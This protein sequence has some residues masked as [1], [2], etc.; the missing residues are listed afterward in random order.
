MDVALCLYDRTHVW[1]NGRMMAGV[2]ETAEREGE[3]AALEAE[4]AQVCG[5]STPPLD[6]W[7]T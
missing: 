2:A 4:M 3:A 7:W 1:Y 6:A 5:F